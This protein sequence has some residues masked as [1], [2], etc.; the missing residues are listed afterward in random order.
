[1][2]PSSGQT[3]LVPEYWVIL[4][5][6]VIEN[7]QRG[8]TCAAGADKNRSPSGSRWCPCWASVR[9]HCKGRPAGPGRNF[10]EG[11]GV[12]RDIDKHKSSCYSRTNVNMRPPC[13]SAVP[14]VSAAASPLT[15]WV[16]LKQ[17]ALMERSCSVR[18]F[19]RIRSILFG[20]LSKATTSPCVR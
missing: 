18:A 4:W 20:I 10:Q 8:I 3:A 13:V 7:L 6:C 14:S 16:L 15:A 9:V 1:M 2:L 12:L 11:R 19:S 17:K 5:W